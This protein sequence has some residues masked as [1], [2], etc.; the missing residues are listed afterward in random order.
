MCHASPWRNLRLDGGLSRRSAKAC[1]PRR[2]SQNGTG[3]SPRLEQSIPFI[4]GTGVC[5]AITDGSA[6]GVTFTVLGGQSA[7]VQSEINR[8]V[9][10]RRRKQHAAEINAR[11]GGRKSEDFTSVESDIEF[12]QRL[13]AIRLVGW[14]GIAEPFHE[15][16][17]LELCQSNADIAT[18][19]TE[20]SNDMANFM[21]SSSPT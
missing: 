4:L 21:K 2:A 7:T 6:S 8:L 10:E 14:S 13:A 19:I 17:A 11:T 9:N 1:R 5:G 16:L 15:D 18:Q 12:G 3:L 20:Q